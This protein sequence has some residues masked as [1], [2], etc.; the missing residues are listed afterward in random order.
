[1]RFF[2]SRLRLL[3]IVAAI[4]WIWMMLFSLSRLSVLPH[5]ERQDYIVRLDTLQPV[6]VDPPENSRRPKIAHSKVAKV[7]VATNK[8][9]NPIIHRALRSHE[10]QNEIHGYKYFIAK[11]EV[12]SD[13]IE[14]KTRKPRGA[15]TKPA[16]LLSIVIS[17]LEKA[18]GERLHWLLYYSLAGVT[19][20]PPSNMSTVG[21]T[22]IL[23][24]STLRPPSKCFYL[25]NLS[26]QRCICLWLQTGMGSTLEPLR[27]GYIL[28]LHL[29][30]LLSFRIQYTC[31][32]SRR[33]IHFR[34]KARSSGY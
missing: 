6:H 14:H 13:L 26:T 2:F 29:C 12:L 1:M 17:E 24:S 28:G 20:V 8:L 21:S 16:Y 10:V 19:I 32:K 4:A 27:S 7:S 18:K 11:N 5:T 23:F 22:L 15:W 25:Q 3:A 9:D 33:R 30:Y 31:R 34:T